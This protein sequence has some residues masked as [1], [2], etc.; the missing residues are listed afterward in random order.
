MDEGNTVVEMDAGDNVCVTLI[1]TALRVNFVVMTKNVLENAYRVLVMI[2][3]HH[4]NTVVLME[5]VPQIVLEKIVLL[6]VIALRLSLVVAHLIEDVCAI[7]LENRVP[8]V[9]VVQRDNVVMK[10]IRFVKQ[11]AAVTWMSLMV[12]EL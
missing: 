11:K 3:V 1:M 10:R 4:I 6:V 8:Q 5:N 12:G 9:R 7:V 2:T